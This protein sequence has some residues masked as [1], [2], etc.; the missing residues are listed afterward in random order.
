MTSMIVFV[1]NVNG[2]G[3]IKSERQTPIPV[4]TYGPDFLA[5]P[6]K[7]VQMHDRANPYRGAMWQHGGDRTPTGVGLCA[8]AES[9]TA[10]HV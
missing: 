5:A 8:E 3:S 6:L 1:I 7:F 10:C 9:L 2:I 4:D